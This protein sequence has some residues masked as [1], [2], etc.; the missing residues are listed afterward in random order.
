MSIFNNLPLLIFLDKF[1]EGIKVTDYPRHIIKSY[2]EFQSL[3][4]RLIFTNVIFLL[5]LNSIKTDLMTKH[6]SDNKIYITTERR[7]SSWLFNFEK[8]YVNNFKTSSSSSLTSPP[9]PPH[10]H[11]HALCI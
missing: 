5:N 1:S 2:L 8:S 10:S 3:M 6:S 9:P 11:P 4:I 7:P